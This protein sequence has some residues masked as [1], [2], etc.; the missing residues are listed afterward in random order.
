MEEI[1][2]LKNGDYFVGVRKTTNDGKVSAGYT[3]ASKNFVFKLNRGENEDIYWAEP[4]KITTCGWW[5]KTV[6][7]AT[8]EEIRAYN[9]AGKPIDITKIKDEIDIYEVY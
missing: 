9:K 6:R 4:N 3:D 5:N 8:E 7:K 2:K 1:V